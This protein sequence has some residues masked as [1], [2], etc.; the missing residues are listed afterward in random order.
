MVCIESIVV[1][2]GGGVGCEDNAWGQLGRPKEGNQKCIV[3]TL[4]SATQILKADQD[5]YQPGV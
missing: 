5:R 4:V 2:V 3:K 1:V